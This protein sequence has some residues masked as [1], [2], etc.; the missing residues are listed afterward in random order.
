ML[1]SLV[2]LLVPAAFAQ[3]SPP[4]AADTVELGLTYAEAA[5]AFGKAGPVD[6]ASMYG[7]WRIAAEV[8][9]DETSAVIVDH[10]QM[11]ESKYLKIEAGETAVNVRHM[12]VT[13]LDKPPMLDLG[14]AEVTPLDDGFGS[15]KHLAWMAGNYL[16]FEF[17]AQ[18]QAKGGGD[19]GDQ[20]RREG[21]ARMEGWIGVYRALENQQSGGFRYFLDCA[22]LDADRRLCA[23]TLKANFPSGKSSQG[24]H[25]TDD[26]GRVGYW[27]LTR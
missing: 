5:A 19:T 13:Q 4:P 10:G 16:H 6:P 27:L 23:I 7:N 12:V 9:E 24:I 21:L 18:V 1:E 3:S 20:A 15:D 11:Y 25:E 22:T 26:F 17:A 14:L 2:L 8:L